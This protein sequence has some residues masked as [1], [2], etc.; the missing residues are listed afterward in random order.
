MTPY[1]PSDWF[2]IIAGDETRAY[3]SAAKSHVPISDADPERTTLIDTMESLIDVLRRANVP[4]YH[5]VSVYRIVR[6]LEAAGL[7]AAA[8][9]VLDALENA[10]L[11][12]RFYGLAGTVESG[13]GVPADDPDAIALVRAAGGDPTVILAPE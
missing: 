3:S 13:A 11:K 5:S 4:P 2:W 6:R 9:A 7:S 1:N 8:L 10:V 12:A